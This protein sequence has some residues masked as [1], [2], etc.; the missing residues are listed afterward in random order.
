MYRYPSQIE[1]GSGPDNSTGP[2]KSVQFEGELTNQSQAAIQNEE[3]EVENLE[4]EV[5]DESHNEPDLQLAKGE[6]VEPPQL[7]Q[8]VAMT[9]INQQSFKQI[10]DDIRQDLI[11]KRKNLLS[12]GNSRARNRGL[13]S[14]DVSGVGLG[15]QELTPS[16]SKNLVNNPK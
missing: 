6:E 7:K 11:S 5:P 3:F 13:L 1:S 9:P 16:V 10:G 2:G 14:S 15:P 8:T 12:Q 4:I